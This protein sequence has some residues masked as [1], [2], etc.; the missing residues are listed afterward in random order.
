MIGLAFKG[1]HSSVFNLI[2]LSDNRTVLSDVVQQT[3]FVPG[4]G[5]VDFGNDTYN[6]KPLTV[7]F[8][9]CAA[10]LE[11]LQIQ[12]EQIGGWFYNDG[13]YYDLIFD[14]A[15]NRKYK[16]KV[17]GKVDLSQSSLVGKIS[18]EF[19]CNPPY[20]FALDNSPVSPA[21]VAGRLLWDTMKLDGTQYLQDLTANGTIKFTVGGAHPVKPVIKLI[22][23]IASGLTL[24]YGAYTW[25]YNAALLFDGIII[26]CAAQT[27]TRMS[28]GVNLF[29]NVDTVKDDYFNLAIGQQSIGVTGVVGVWPNDLTIAVEFT[30]IF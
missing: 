14:D 16:A 4:Y 7:N 8:T 25:K 10:S 30:P 3:K 6:P 15:P 24:T 21:D 20:P 27:V 13:T 1:I 5:I 11:D 26:D 28:D 18:V 9:Y 23:N 22:G 17:T 12:T 2:M 29:P 19:I